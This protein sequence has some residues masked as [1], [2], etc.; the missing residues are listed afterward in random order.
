MKKIEIIYCSLWN[1]KPEAVSL[2]A[3]LRRRG[4]KYP[5]DLVAGDK[6][7]FDVI[8]DGETI[9]SKAISGDFPRVSETAE[10]AKMINSWKSSDGQSN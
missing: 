8:L 4:V 10:I 7:I 2:A 5:I 9:F 3:E 6:G 1:Y